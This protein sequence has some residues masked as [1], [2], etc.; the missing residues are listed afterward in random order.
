[1]DHGR[2]APVGVLRVALTALCTAGAIALVGLLGCTETPAPVPEG[3]GTTMT[4]VP[5]VRWDEPG[6]WFII[7]RDGLWD[8]PASGRL[9]SVLASVADT[10]GISRGVDASA[11]RLLPPPV[12]IFDSLAV[13]T[14]GRS[15]DDWL[16]GR[17]F[18]LGS[19]TIQQ[20]GDSLVGWFVFVL[21]DAEGTPYKW[22]IHRPYV[23]VIALD[24]I[25]EVLFGVERT[26][27]GARLVRLR[28]GW[29]HR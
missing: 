7:R 26:D 4:P 24:P 10:A 2:P 13:A 12:G 15:P 18:P 21:R 9:D 16:P 17:V 27:E 1:M 29:E 14:G 11:L 5:E 25:E 23:D 6:L 8:L 20:Y 3:G 19:G 28:Y 22:P